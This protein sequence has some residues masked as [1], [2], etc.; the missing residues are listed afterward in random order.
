MHTL[1]QFITRVPLTLV[2]VTKR[3]RSVKSLRHKL[4]WC[5]ICCL[6]SAFHT[7]TP[8]KCIVQVSQN[9]I[10]VSETS[11]WLFRVTCISTRV[12]LPFCVKMRF[13][14]PVTPPRPRIS[15]ISCRHVKVRCGEMKMLKVG[16]SS[17]HHRR[18]RTNIT[19]SALLD[20]KFLCHICSRAVGLCY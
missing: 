12:S 11:K 6:K 4:L 3:W 1:F 14:T 17:L 16:N 7:C 20:I 15:V 19:T 13:V 9:T 8:G 18:R 5:T 10:Y 2:E